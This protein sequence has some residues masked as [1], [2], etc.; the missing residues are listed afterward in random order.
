M[1]FLI[2][3]IVHV[4]GNVLWLGGGVAAALAFVL[5][6]QE[7]NAVRLPAARALRKVILYIVTPGMLMSIVAGL[8]MLI[9]FWTELYAKAPWAHTKLT[10]GIIAAGFTGA[11]TGKIRRAAAGAEVKPASI[12]LAGYVLLFSGIAG[13]VAVFTKFGQH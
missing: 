5:L 2:S 6:A 12:K 11:M 8:T 7:D 4:I 3:K 9:G 13:V 10:V 1:W